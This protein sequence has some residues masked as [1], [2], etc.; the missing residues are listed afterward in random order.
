MHRCTP[1]HSHHGDTTTPRYD[2]TAKPKSS[3]LLPE[4]PVVSEALPAQANTGS[5]EIEG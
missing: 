2:Q 1:T 3:A 5:H 4:A